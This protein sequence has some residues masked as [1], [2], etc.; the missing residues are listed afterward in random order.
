MVFE[1]SILQARLLGGLGA[2]LI[3]AGCVSKVDLGGSDASSDGTSGSSDAG[4]DIGALTNICPSEVPKDG[5]P[6][7]I[8][9]LRCEYGSSLVAECNTIAYCYLKP[10]R[11]MVTSPAAACPLSPP[12]NSAACPAT[13][14]QIPQGSACSATVDCVYPEGQCDCGLSQAE[15]DG[16]KCQAQPA[17]CPA[18]PPRFGSAC[19]P[20]DLQCNYFSCEPSGAYAFCSDGV[21]NGGPGGCAIANPQASDAGKE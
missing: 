5:D 3:V 1:F 21:W 19:S 6:C 11:F 10:L 13:Y 18:L 15:S 4:A 17:G 20:S 9:N 2:A 14:A 12:T 16:W 7:S 8:V